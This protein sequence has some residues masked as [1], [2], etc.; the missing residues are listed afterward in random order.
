MTCVK[1]YIAG[2]LQKDLRHKSAEHQAN[3][4]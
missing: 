4:E 3:G 1:E 2:Y